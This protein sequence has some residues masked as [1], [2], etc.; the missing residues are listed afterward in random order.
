LILT[1]LTGWLL[2]AMEPLF[3][4]G[5][6]PLPLVSVI[7][8]S[9]GRP[10]LVQNA[11]GSVLAQDIPNIEVIVVDDGSPEQLAPILK[12]I[13][14]DRI[15]CLR[16]DVSLGAPAARNIGLRLARGEYVAFLDDDDLWLSDKLSR[17]LGCFKNAGNDCVLVGCSFA[18]TRDGER[19]RTQ[20]VPN[21]EGLFEQLLARNIIGGCSVPLI[22]R[23]AL[24]R[25]GGFDESFESCQDWELWL[26]LLR[27]GT[28]AFASE[29]LVLRQV[30]QGQ[31][32]SD[33][34]RK[35][36][37]RQHLLEKN[38]QEMVAHPYVFA[39]HLRRLGTLTL[40]DGDR[41]ESRKA[42][43]KAL[44]Q[45]IS[46]W[47]NWAGFFLSLLPASWGKKLAHRAGTMQLA[48][49]VFYH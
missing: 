29:T 27:K 22:R 20:G 8:P 33:L 18:Y 37:G 1:L 19:I 48:E 21:L 43:G 13:F 28:A 40:M 17:Q 16:N 47:R 3:M 32:T 14:G 31:I 12:G 24:E 26:R 15:R 9:K 30:H 38:F 7:I 25:V 35:I 41:R 39:E 4:D 6:S 46:D 5:A 10:Q 11:V 2:S 34:K 44:A 49:V 36:V 23:T 42:Y 45:R